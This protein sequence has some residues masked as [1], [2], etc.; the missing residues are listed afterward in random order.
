MTHDEAR[1]IA[2]L[3]QQS[4]AAFSF[5]AL[6]VQP[7]KQRRTVSSVMAEAGGSQHLGGSVFGFVAL[8]FIYVYDCVFNKLSNKQPILDAVD[9]VRLNVSRNDQLPGEG[10]P[11]AC[12]RHLRNCFAHG[13]F[14]YQSDGQATTTVELQDENNRK[15]QTFHAVCDAVALAEVAEKVLIAAHAETASLVNDGSPPVERRP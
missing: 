15:Q 14:T 10:P 6:A 7:E 13:R 3:L 9:P 8:A 5:L 12:L 4:H 11:T 2:R 1:S